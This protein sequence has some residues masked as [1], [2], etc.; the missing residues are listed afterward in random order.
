[1]TFERTSS[2]MKS[3]LKRLCPIPPDWETSSDEALE[4]M[5]RSADEVMRPVS[6]R[7]SESESA[8]SA[9]RE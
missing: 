9:G 6:A 8:E 2:D 7:P 5:C 1:L 3:P 4:Q